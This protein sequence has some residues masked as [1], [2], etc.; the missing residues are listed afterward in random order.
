[1]QPINFQEKHTQL[2]ISTYPHLCDWTHFFI[3]QLQVFLSQPFV[4]RLFTPLFWVFI[5]VR[6]V[7]NLKDSITDNRRRDLH[8]HMLQLAPSSSLRWFWWHLS[9]HSLNLVTP[10]YWVFRSQNTKTAYKIQFAR[11]R[12]YLS[13]LQFC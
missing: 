12:F 2:Y 11:L 13:Y 5:Y 8:M 10:P 6:V 9:T 3:K 4:E 7:F 1:M